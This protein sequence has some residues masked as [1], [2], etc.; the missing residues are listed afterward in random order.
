MH[1]REELP[2]KNKKI[3]RNNKG[4]TLTEL[5]IVVAIIAVLSAATTLAVLRY[6]K[7]SRF[8]KDTQLLDDFRARVYSDYAYAISDP[9]KSATELTKKFKEFYRGPKSYT[10]KQSKSKVDIKYNQINISSDKYLV[11]Y[12][13]NVDDVKI[14]I[15]GA[16]PVDADADP[17][18]SIGDIKD[19]TPLSRAQY[20]LNKTDT[21]YSKGVAVCVLDAITG[22]EY[23]GWAIDRGKGYN[24]ADIVW[25]EDL[26]NDSDL[27]K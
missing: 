21:T 2:M 6:I 22:K 20:R 16:I 7:K 13:N 26:E 4:V 3:L 27:Y 9:E 10:E 14:D 18:K 8:A 1:Q 11:F 17:K 25:Q 5:L 15:P 24:L 12:Y 23:C 19:A